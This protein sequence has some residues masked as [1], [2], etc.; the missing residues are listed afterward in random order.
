MKGSY[1]D[2]AQVPSEE[3]LLNFVESQDG[4]LNYDDG[5]PDLALNSSNQNESYF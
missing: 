3:I 4:P 1:Q 2:S 5:R